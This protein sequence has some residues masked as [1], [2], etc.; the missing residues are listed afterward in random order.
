MKVSVVGVEGCGRT[1]FLGLFYETLVQMTTAKG[2]AG[3]GEIRFICEPGTVKCLGDIRL[4]LISR[5]WPLKERKQGITDCSMDIGFR[6]GRFFGLLPSNEFRTATIVAVEVGKRDVRVLE[7]MASPDGGHC[8]PGALSEDL[9]DALHATIIVLLIDASIV[10][11]AKA[12]DRSS[13]KRADALNASLISTTM[14]LKARD[15]NDGMC[16]SVP[17]PVIV[18][19]KFDM[20]G[21]IDIAEKDVRT[22]AGEFLRVNFPEVTKVLEEQRPKGMDGTAE[23]FTSGMR[24]EGSEG[25]LVPVPVIDKGQVCIDYT[26]SGYGSLIKVIR[27]AAEGQTGT[28][29]RTM[30]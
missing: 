23:V 9:L 30:R 16:R 21:K 4:D 20:V 19:T 26:V 11:T 10:A 22:V 3:K 8:D 13:L 28:K 27:R 14:R 25:D 7:E 24:T 12:D 15:I 18:L 6:K 17:C 1:V 5:R 2:N 29:V